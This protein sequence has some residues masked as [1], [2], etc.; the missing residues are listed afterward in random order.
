[1]VCQLDVLRKCVTVDMLRKTLRSLPQ[2]LDETYERI[3][4]NIDEQHSDYVHKVLQWLAFSARPVTL[5]EVADAL[6]VNLDHGCLLDLDQQLRNPQDILT[7]CSTLVTISPPAF[8]SEGTGNGMFT[9][10]RLLSLITK[11]DNRD[12]QTSS[13]FSQRISGLS[14]HSTWACNTVQSC[15]ETSRYI[16]LTY[17]SGLSV[18]I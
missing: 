4:S 5:A 7:I 18:S 16:Y 8:E 15:E 14:L 10:F 13:F 6:S 17:M 3:L 9:N 11:C 2:S 12:S 1:V